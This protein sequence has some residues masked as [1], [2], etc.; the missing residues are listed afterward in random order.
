M[1][2]N[3]AGPTP[4]AK[5]AVAVCSSLALLLILAVIFY[6]LRRHAKAKRYRSPPSTRGRV[7]HPIFLPGSSST[8]LMSPSALASDHQHVPLSPPPRLRERRLLYSVGGSASDKT[9]SVPGTPT[10]P[11]RAYSGFPQVPP[12]PTMAGKAAQPRTEKSIDDRELGLMMQ[13]VGLDRAS[14]RT[15]SLSSLG[16]RRTT[17]ASGCSTA[18]FSLRPPSPQAL[19]PASSGAGP[20]PLRPPRPHDTPLEIPDLVRPDWAGTHAQIPS[21][22]PNRALPPAPVGSPSYPSS[23]FQS[24][25]RHR[26]HD[27]IGVAIG[28]DSRSLAPGDPSRDQGQNTGQRRATDHDSW[29]SW[30]GGGPGVTFPSPTKR[31]TG[32][33]RADSFVMDEADLERLAGRY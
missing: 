23:S 20:S 17:T 3:P 21:P 14:G 24:A 27:D 6:C 11:P 10:A 29:G 30:G 33:G 5:A 2:N 19:S 18:A 9:I 4:G 12:S 25:M 8:P 16:S 22:P 32:N 26:Q 28:I 31:E 15:A 13:P 7:E 1:A